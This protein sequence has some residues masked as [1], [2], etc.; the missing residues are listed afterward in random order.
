M[1]KRFPSLADILPVLAIISFL[2]YGWSILVFLWKLPGWLFF[3]SLGEIA[4]LFAFELA[5]NL[6]ESLAVLALI[7]LVTALLPPR[8]LKEHFP[9]RGGAIALA[10]VGLMILLLH[11]AVTKK[12]GLVSSWPM[13]TLVIALLSASLAWVASRFGMAGR[14][15]AGLG[16]RL[17]VFLFILLPLSVI[18]LPVVLVRLFL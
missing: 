18:S 3:L 11:L 10:V 8:F 5:V 15:F 1:L 14:F 9:A 4:V 7:L 17:T 12:I 6:I 13:W 16:D 2:F